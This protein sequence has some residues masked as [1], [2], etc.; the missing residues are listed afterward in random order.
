MAKALKIIVISLLIILLAPAIILKI[1]PRKT[2]ISFLTVKTEQSEKKPD[3]LVI[4]SGGFKKNLVPGV[5]TFERINTLKEALNK[6]P[7]TP[8]IVLDYNTGKKLIASKLKEESKNI[9]ILVSNKYS[10]KE[11]LGGTENN[12]AELISLIKERNDIKTIALITSPYHEKRVKLILDYYLQK[13]NLNIDYFFIHVKNKGEIVN[14]DFSRYLKLVLH[15]VSG[16]IY[17]K[18]SR[19]Y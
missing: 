13:E 5:S 8:V 19:L 6:Y 17:F 12:I 3:A 18:L 1:T 9:R 11:K 10:Y 16:I 14:C 2:F 15:E 7:D 4:L